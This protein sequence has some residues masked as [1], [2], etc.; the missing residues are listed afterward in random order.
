VITEAALAGKVDWLTGLKENVILG[1]LLPAG[2]G[3]ATRLAPKPEGEV[4]EVDISE[5]DDLL[6]AEI[7]R[8]LS[9]VVD[10]TDAEGSG[11]STDEAA[12]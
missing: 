4:V 1:R 10:D 3:L 6:A 7:A 9:E 2:T 8:E 11:M 12:A 5:D